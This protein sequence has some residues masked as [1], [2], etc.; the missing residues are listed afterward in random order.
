MVEEAKEEETRFTD[1]IWQWRN[2]VTDKLLGFFPRRTAQ[3]LVN[4]QKEGILAVRS[5]LDRGIEILDS[6][7]KRNQDRRFAPVSTSGSLRLVGIRS[8]TIG[9]QGAA[10]VQGDPA[11]FS[12]RSYRYM[13]CRH[14]APRFH[15]S[16]MKFRQRLPP[17]LCSNKFW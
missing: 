4:A 17:G 7:L 11:V 5:L 10:S 9:L 1:Q 14:K 8:A 6:D 13:R 15:C 2:T 3:H 16:R 12:E